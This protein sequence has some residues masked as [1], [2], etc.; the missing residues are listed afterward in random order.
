MKQFRFIIIIALMLIAPGLLF[1]GCDDDDDDNDSTVD[2]KGTV[3]FNANG[4]GFVHDGFTSEDGWNI[5]FTHVYIN[6]EGPT[7]YQVAESS[8]KSTRHAGHPHASIPEGSAHAALTGQYFL[9]LKKSGETPVFEVG[10]VTDAT[11]GNYNYLNFNIVQTNSTDNPTVIAE[12]TVTVSD[13]DGYSIVLIG[14]ATYGNPIT[15]TVDFTIK[16][17]EE[18]ALYGCGPL[19]DLD[20]DGT[21]D[22]V[23]ADG[24]TAETQMTFHFDHIFGDYGD[25]GDEPESTDPEDIN[26]WGIGFDPFAELIDGVYVEGVLQEGEFTDND[27][28]QEDMKTNML[29][30][31]YF[32]FIATLKTLC[33]IGEG[34]CHCGDVE[35]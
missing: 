13:Y 25:D 24:G 9:D 5:S 35:E 27:I 34:H 1:F 20:E 8:T 16:F 18:M 33:H 2:G 7:A 28:T 12:D 21:N 15:T 30:A 17:D 3:I 31:D 4:E 29:N 10:R 23:L 6:I 22:G 26:F 19:L 14:T 11:I 32:Q